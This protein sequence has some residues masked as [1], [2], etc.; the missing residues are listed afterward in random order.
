M[1]YFSA[2]SVQNL[3]SCDERL[4]LVFTQV[5]KYFDCKVL[6]GHR[7]EERQNALYHAGKSQLMFPDGKHNRDP[8]LAADVIP[9]PIDWSDRERMSYFAGFVK[10]TAINVR[11]PHEKKNWRIRWGGDWDGDWKVRDNVFDDLVHF[12]IIQNG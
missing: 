5:I 4:Q 7:N 12:E 2:T 10:A 6:E 3:A 1:P 11:R 9:Y 8:S